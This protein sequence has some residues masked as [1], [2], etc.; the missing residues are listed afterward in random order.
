MTE[1]TRLRPPPISLADLRARDSELIHLSVAA[2]ARSLP[3]GLAEESAKELPDSVR[4]ALP[5]EWI[6]P[7]LATGNVE[8]PRDR[9]VEALPGGVKG[10]FNLGQSQSVSLPL[11]EILQNLPAFGVKEFPPAPPEFSA[12]V[13]TPKPEAAPHRAHKAAE[14]GETSA[15]QSLF[16]TEDELTIE[17]IAGLVAALPGL[18]GCAAGSRDAVAISGRVPKDFPSSELAGAASELFSAADG[19][20]SRLG[21]G[22]AAACTVY[23]GGG[24]ASFIARGH[25]RLCVFH[26]GSRGFLPGVREKLDAVASEMAKSF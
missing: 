3:A 4:V 16:M 22:T 14:T 19:A 24:A 17:T 15:L 1:T 20:G 5:F 8:V 11:D 26:R 25:V 13:L 12:P 6:E 10:G 21:L 18:E 23:Y 2:I 7:Q 9:F